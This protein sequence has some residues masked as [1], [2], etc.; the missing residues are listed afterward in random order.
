MF[1]E[2]LSALNIPKDELEILSKSLDVQGAELLEWRP[3]EVSATKFGTFDV[4]QKVGTFTSQA[5]EVISTEVTGLGTELT[6]YAANID[7]FG[8]EG[9]QA[10]EV[11]AA[12]M[13]IRMKTAGDVEVPLL[14][15]EGEGV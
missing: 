14:P 5:T 9:E 12:E 1:D 4:A 8:K 7:A 13:Q 3:P 6:E 11:T 2:I 15:T 10:D